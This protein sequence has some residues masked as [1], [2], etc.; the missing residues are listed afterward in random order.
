M[1]DLKVVTMVVMVVTMV[2]L[3]VVT[4]VVLVWTMVDLKVVTMVVTMVAQTVYTDKYI[5]QK[6]GRIN[7]QKSQTSSFVDC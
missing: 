2:D 5:C 6:L 4:M 1:V 3:K 7:F